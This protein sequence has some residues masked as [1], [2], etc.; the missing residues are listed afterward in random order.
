M[1][2]FRDLKPGSIGWLNKMPFI[3]LACNV[4]KCRM[5]GAW[6]N[7]YTAVCLDNGELLK[8]DYN[9][10]IKTNETGYTGP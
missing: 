10:P 4:K 3:K 6:S 5:L 9:T 2:L 1:K 8:I 7:I